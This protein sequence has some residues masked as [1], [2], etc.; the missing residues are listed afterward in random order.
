MRFAV[1]FPAILAVFCS[2]GSDSGEGLVKSGDSC[3]QGQ[4]GWQLCAESA[5]GGSAVLKCQTAGLNMLWVAVEECEWGCSKGLCMEPPEED[6]RRIVDVGDSSAGNVDAEVTHT[7]SA[8]TDLPDLF[9]QPGQPICLDEETRGICNDQ[10][11]AYDAHPCQEPSVCDNG[12]CLEVVCTPG[13]LKEECVG[14]TAMYICNEAGTA[15]EAHNC[16]AGHTCYGGDCVNWACNPG[17]KI[18]KGM[19][20]VQECVDDGQGGYAWEVVEECAGG[21]CDDGKCVSACEVNVKQ[22]TYL[23]CGYYAVDLDNIEGGMYEPVG[24]VVS[25]PKG[26]GAAEITITNTATGKDLTSGELGGAPLTVEPGNLQVYTLPVPFDLDGST[27]TNRSF[28][29]NSTTPVTVHQF[30]PLTGDNIFTNDASLLLPAH[31]GGT[32]YLVMSWYLRTWVETLR[33]FATVVATQSGET[34]VQVKATSAVVP[35]PGVS[36]MVKGQTKSFTMQKGDVLN[37]EVNGNEGD[38]L[39]GTQITADKK[40]SVFGGHECANIHVDYE[41]CDHIEQQLFPLHAWGNKYIGDP[42]HPRTAT[43]IDTWRILAGDD[44]T[45]V[46]LD[47]PVAGP[48]NLSKGQWV[49][50]DTQ[51]PFEATGTGRFLLGHYLQSC[52]YPGHAVFCSD[53]GGQLGIGDPAFTLAVPVSQYIE[54]YVLLT[55]ADYV[56]DYINFVFAPGTQVMLDGAAVTEPLA[57]VGSGG[58]GMLQKAVSPGVHT[59]QADG[60]VGLTVY[61]YGCHVSYAYP[62]G[63]KLEDFE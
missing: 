9:C 7:D 5:D 61:G 42:F 55:P 18:C 51:E 36:A 4:I 37:L 22:N 32:E 2:C 59:V 58:F 21:L 46:S 52:N 20:A 29:I 54:A 43:H 3:D 12:F 31:A 40:I 24:V 27:H 28:E 11:S 48:F 26:A 1:C 34:I 14:P 6:L 39:T 49:E 33:G 17:D 44:G 60:P 38:D 63:L 45:T 53:F 62:G 15:F 8:G 56:E 13:E 50:F 30:N 25:A 23:G 35:G 57:P 41:R 10:G 16:D 47:P 19:T